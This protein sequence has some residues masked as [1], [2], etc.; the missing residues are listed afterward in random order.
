MNQKNNTFIESIQY[1]R[2]LAVNH[3]LFFWNIILQPQIKNNKDK[4]KKA[5][6]AIEFFQT[7]LQNSLLKKI[8]TVEMCHQIQVTHYVIL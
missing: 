2:T 3:H 8:K 1:Q 6:H 5:Q 4:K 7:K